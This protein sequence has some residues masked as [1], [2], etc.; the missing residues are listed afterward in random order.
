MNTTNRA[1]ILINILNSFVTKLFIIRIFGYQNNTV[2][3][4]L[5]GINNM[6]YKC[7]VIKANQT[8]FGLHPGTFATA[9]NVCRDVMELIHLNNY[10]FKFTVQKVDTIS[11]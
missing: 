7:F 2:S 11:V 4:R 6:F 8:L 1:F 3:K 9:K 5:N 10:F